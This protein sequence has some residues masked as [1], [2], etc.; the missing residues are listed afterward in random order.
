MDL[1]IRKGVKQDL[2]CVLSLINITPAN[3]KALSTFLPSLLPFNLSAN[4]KNIKFAKNVPYRVDLFFF[5][6][7]F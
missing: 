3:I 2:P 7:Y 4:G 6:R 5:H 1:K